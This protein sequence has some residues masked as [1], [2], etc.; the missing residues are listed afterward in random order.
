MELTKEQIQQV[1]GYLDNK[2][3]NFIDLKVEVLDHM[4]SDIED[5][6]LLEN[7]TFNYAFATAKQKWNS[8]LKETSSM[9]FSI[10]FSAP[11]IVIQKAKKVY[12]KQYV[13]LLA[14]YFLPFLILTH[15]NFKIENPTE[16]SFFTLLKAVIILSLIAFFY[17]LLFKNDKIE[18]TYGF[19]LKSQSLGAF[20][21]LIV[22]AIFFTRLE[23]LN[24]I[25]IGIFCSFIYMTL[26]NFHFFKKHK[27]TIKKYK[28][29]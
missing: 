9:F 8:Q 17:M 21:G 10:G 15:F 5:N 14:S 28:I 1:E 27:E 11:K 26:S 7:V 29:L 3:F 4:I 2:R 20:T 12:W 6:I 16:F 13:F 24:G 19:I 23:E 18:T 22:L 25:N